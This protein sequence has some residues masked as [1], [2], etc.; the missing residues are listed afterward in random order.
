MHEICFWR[1]TENSGQMPE[2][3]RATTA[4]LNKEDIKDIFTSLYD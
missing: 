2:M 1:L 3:I 4:G